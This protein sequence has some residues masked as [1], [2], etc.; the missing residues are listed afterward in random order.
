LILNCCTRSLMDSSD[1]SFYD[2][3]DTTVPRSLLQ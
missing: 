1:V 3:Q 2:V